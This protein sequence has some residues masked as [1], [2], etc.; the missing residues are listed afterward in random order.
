MI[1]HFQHKKY[2]KQQLTLLHIQDLII[3]KKQSNNNHNNH[4]NY[5]N[6]KNN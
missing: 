1:N 2:K 4:N 6:N 3:I 5:K